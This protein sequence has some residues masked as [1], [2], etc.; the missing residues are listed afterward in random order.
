[1]LNRKTF[2]TI[3]I[4][5][6]AG[7]MALVGLGLASA[8]HDGGSATA[9]R[10]FSASSVESGGT[11]TVTIDNID[12][13]ATGLSGLLGAIT[14]TLPDGFTFVSTDLADSTL[15]A[16]ATGDLQFILFGA[17]SFNYTV[18]AS[19]TPGTYTFS[20]ML[21]DG[22]TPPADHPVGGSSMVTVVAGTPPTTPVT[23]TTPVPAC[24]APCA[25]RSFMPDPVS[26]GGLLEVTL[27]PIGVGFGRIVE[28]L[29]EG[30]TYQDSGLSGIGSDLVSHTAGVITFTLIGN[31]SFTYSVTASSTVGDH[32]FQGTLTDSHRAQHAVAGDSTVT[33]RRPVVRP[34][35]APATPAPAPAECVDAVSVG[36]SVMGT[37]ADDDGC[38]SSASGRGNA[39]YYGFTL[40]GQQMVTIS[41]ESMDADTYLYLRSGNAQSGMALDENDDHEGSLT[42]SQ[43]SRTLA[44]GSYTIEATT[45][46][47]GET[48]SFTLS[49]SGTG[50]PPATDVCTQ[51]V[52]GAMSGAWAEGCESS[53]TGRGH[54]R[55][56][57]FTLAEERMVTINLESTDADPYLYLRSGD[58]KS[59]AAMH[60]NDDHDGSLSESQISE[61]LAAGSYTIEATTYASGV[62]GS[63]TLT[64]SGLDAP[65]VGC[66]E[67]V[68]VGGSTMGS[69]AAG[70]ESSVSGRGYTRYY[71]FT[72]NSEQTVTITLES[73]DA[74]PYLYLRA[75]DAQSGMA[76]HENDDYS[77]SL[78]KSQ[79]REM[80]AA[81][82][83]TIEAT[84]YD[85]GKTGSFTLS[86]AGSP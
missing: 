15:A 11:L 10:S 31:D 16:G 20:G 5:M 41:L 53:V 42:M 67:A 30:F 22:G 45:Y 68:S 73:T 82:S 48:G 72:L 62:T 21:R 46:A 3:L 55:Y 71:T 28:T 52:S 75:G 50:A 79:I 78:E 44:A 77:G 80:L 19:S 43:I 13:G 64:V 38:E 1:M 2:T 81:G 6:A 86:V 61:M 76:L 58:A 70:C 24:T 34:R 8:N 59:G 66:A 83:Y 56:Y 69:W 32:T 29:P 14:E 36:G 51:A 25:E 17:T 49:V 65:A 35:P 74:D 39:R 27:N 37:W 40:S 12:V 60:E 57:T 85:S 84:T 26:T 9:T 54:A 63:F 47:P 23:P 18:T 33:V 7:V 4:A